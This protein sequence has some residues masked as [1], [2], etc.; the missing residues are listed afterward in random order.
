MHTAHVST[1]LHAPT[2]G[3]G[4]SFTASMKTEIWQHHALNRLLIVKH[5]PYVS[6]CLCKLKSSDRLP[7]HVDTVPPS[8]AVAATAPLAPLL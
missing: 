8:P 7:V 2:L 1:Y 5:A 6:T 3:C 4:T